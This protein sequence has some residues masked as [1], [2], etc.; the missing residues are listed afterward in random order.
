MIQFF[1]KIRQKMLINSNFSKYLMYALGEITLVVIGILL[2]LAINEWKNKQSIKS[3]EIATLNKL[4]KDLE[5]DNI[6]FINNIE[7][8]TDRTKV[9]GNAKSII[10]KKSLSDNEIREVMFYGGAEHKD[11]NPRRTTYE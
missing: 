5:S 1:R 7:F 3:D 8:Y 6:R 11:L 2:A 9:L 4:V 10:Y